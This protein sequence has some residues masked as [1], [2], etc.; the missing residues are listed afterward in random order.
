M[1]K[2]Y[3]LVK[4]KGASKIS[5]AIPVK[6][7]VTLSKARTTVR[8]SLKKGYQ[9]RV[10]SEAQFKRLL[11]KMASTSRKRMK[12]RK[13]R[14]KTKARRKNKPKR[15]KKRWTIQTKKN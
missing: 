13:T 6:K 14:R 3:I 5:G 7:G 15:R 9:A 4:R 10:V 8:K 2:Y 1:P 11:L 12:K